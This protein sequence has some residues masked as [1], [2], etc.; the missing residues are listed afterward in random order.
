MSYLS[1]FLGINNQ[2]YSA[3]KGTRP[4]VSYGQSYIDIPLYGSGETTNGAISYRPGTD[5]FNSSFYHATGGTN[6]VSFI[7]WAELTGLGN[8]LFEA[9]GST[10]SFFYPGTLVI[11]NLMFSSLA[12]GA[13][14]FSRGGGANLTALYNFSVRALYGNVTVAAFN[15]NPGLTTVTIGDIAIGNSGYTFSLQFTGCA[16]TAQSVENIL[17]AADNGCPTGVPSTA[18]INLSG[19]TSSGASALTSAAAAARTSLIAKGVSITLN[20]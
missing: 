15:S 20:P 19:G 7:G 18:S 8:A 12:S 3:F 9:T 13:A 4:N 5:D 10:W 17:V 14:S 11:S 1:S 16:L 2:G 6:Q